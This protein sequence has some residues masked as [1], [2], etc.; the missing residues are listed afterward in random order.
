MLYFLTAKHVFTN[1]IFDRAITIHLE[2]DFLQTLITKDTSQQRLYL[3]MELDLAIIS[4]MF[5]NKSQVTKNK[6]KFKEA[7][8]FEEDF[9]HPEMGE[10]V[11]TQVPFKMFNS[12]IG[13][14]VGKR[15]RNLLTTQITEYGFSGAIAHNTK[16]FVGIHLGK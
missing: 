8:I 3:S 9:E 6:K 1:H 15:Q 13:N 2:N 12:G 10:R 14:I 11:V 16:G 4:I 7:C 5:V